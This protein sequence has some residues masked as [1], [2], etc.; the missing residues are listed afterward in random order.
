[1]PERI[2]LTT[3]KLA[4]RKVD[5]IGRPASGGFAPPSAFIPILPG[6]AWRTPESGGIEK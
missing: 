4:G 5:W 1:M 6:A 3:L 2:H